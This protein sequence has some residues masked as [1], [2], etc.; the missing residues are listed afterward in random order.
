MKFPFR[1]AF[2]NVYVGLI[3]LAMS[4]LCMKLNAEHASKIFM[5]LVVFHV[6]CLFIPFFKSVHEMMDRDDDREI[7]S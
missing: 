3:M 1:S 4:F 2:M 6:I 5:S 7:K